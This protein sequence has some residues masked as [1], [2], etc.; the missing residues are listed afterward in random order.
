MM[1]AEMRYIALQCI[2]VSASA[3]GDG[4]ARRVPRSTA[5]QWSAPRVAIEGGAILV[6]PRGTPYDGRDGRARANR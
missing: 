1:L 6:K 4:L 2:I 5:G 3:P